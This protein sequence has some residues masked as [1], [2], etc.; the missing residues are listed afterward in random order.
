M[1]LKD[2]GK[3]WRHTREGIWHKPF[4]ANRL[5][6]RVKEWRIHYEKTCPGCK[7][8]FLASPKWVNHCSTICGNSTN[9]QFGQKHWRW[10]GGRAEAASGYIL[11]RHNTRKYVPEHRFLM[12]QLLGRKLTS[13]EVVHHINE[14]K[15]DN[16]LENLQVLSRAEHA[17]HHHKGKPKLLKVP[18][19]KR[20]GAT[21]NA[22]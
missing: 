22:I 4:I 3:D 16:R 7:E 10:K 17:S 21:T 9:K 12:E 18:R 19:N 1:K 8:L 20:I 15:S 11:I 14:N 5:G 2:V 13:N 6:K